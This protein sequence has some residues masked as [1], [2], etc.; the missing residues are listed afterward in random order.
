MFVH[1]QVCSLL[2]WSLQNSNGTEVD[3]N[4]FDLPYNFD[5]VF[6]NMALEYSLTDSLNNST[7]LIMYSESVEQQ[8]IS[9]E[10]NIILERVGDARV[11]PFDG[12][13]SVII[14]NVLAPLSIRV[15]S[16][17][18][19][20]TALSQVNFFPNIAH[21]F[22]KFDR[23]SSLVKSTI[24][25][26]EESSLFE[27]LPNTSNFAPNTITALTLGHLPKEDQ[28]DHLPNLMR[29]VR[30]LCLNEVITIGL[31]RDHPVPAFQPEQLKQF[32]S[33]HLN[34]ALDAFELICG[35]SQCQAEL[36]GNF[37]D[38]HHEKLLVQRSFVSRMTYLL[39]NYMR[40]VVSA[41]Q[42]TDPSHNAL[43]RI[44]IAV[45]T[46]KL[47]SRILKLALV[48]PMDVGI[49]EQASKLMTTLVNGKVISDAIVVTEFA[50]GIN[51]ALESCLKKESEDKEFN[52]DICKNLSDIRNHFPSDVVR[53]GVIETF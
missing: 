52:G 25:V 21:E 9:L 1:L 40:P 33:V 31:L 39:F 26:C 5:D 51:C 20:N 27:F 11:V 35:H 7:H 50:V 42:K 14:G 17:K 53:C 43:R 12:L 37:E 36:L 22:D 32:L 28:A 49:A 4:S 23:L 24:D 29:W 6:P 16:V 3:S 48:S 45:A 2:E 34:R 44:S 13:F 38:T 8:L 15:T 18:L 47:L 46:P 41:V 10:D 30:E 19:L